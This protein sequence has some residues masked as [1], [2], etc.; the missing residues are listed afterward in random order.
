MN[1]T[2][3]H[4]QVNICVFKVEQGE[5]HF[6][7]G[8]VQVWWQPPGRLEQTEVHI[9]RLDIQGPEVVALCLHCHSGG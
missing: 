8:D 2:L 3:E 6:L 4:T 7:L 5:S 1:K 9:G